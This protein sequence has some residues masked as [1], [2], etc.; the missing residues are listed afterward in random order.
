[1]KIKHL[2]RALILG[3]LLSI[4]GAMSSC[5][6]QTQTQAQA[7]DG[8]YVK[9]G[10]G[11]LSNVMLATIQSAAYTPTLP[12][13]ATI[14]ESPSNVLSPRTENDNQNQI[15]AAITNLS[16]SG[17][18]T[19]LL[20][21]G[22]FR[23]K[24]PIILKSNVRLKGGGQDVSI[25]KRDE[26]WTNVEGRGMLESG[27]YIED[28]TISDLSIDG[29]RPESYRMSNQ[30]PLF[31]IEITIDNGGTT[32]NNRVYIT[33]VKI[34]NTGMGCH[35]KHTNNV[36]LKG[37]Y[38]VGNGTLASSTHSLPTFF[39]NV[40]LRSIDKAW[41]YGTNY[42]KDSPGGNGLNITH[43]TNLTVEDN[44]MTGNNF[45]GIRLGGSSSIIL[46]RGNTVSSNTDFGIGLAYD[47]TGQPQNFSII[48]NTVNNNDNNGIYIP[49][50]TKNGEV[51]GNSLSGNSPLNIKKGTN[52][53]NVS[54]QA[55]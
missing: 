17:G 10:E 48:D 46:V 42:F 22:I 2:T 20:G 3:A 4:T 15:N 35:I 33:N 27:G 5:E 25:I 28:L 55:N 45:R 38:I 26:S 29:N 6:K 1:M 47:E 11:A 36:I 39:H 13:K 44:I 53:T 19:V 41:V 51:Q 54:C 49:N 31:G 34:V 16:N 7:Q 14:I 24:S 52:L 18:G 50:N 12:T 40:Y 43:L 30:F 37:N 23:I 8:Q 21:S 9:K 32:R